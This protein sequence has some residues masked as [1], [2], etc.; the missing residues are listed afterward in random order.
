MG[1]ARV[2]VVVWIAGASR[3]Q[4]TGERASAAGLCCVSPMVYFYSVVLFKEVAVVFLCKREKF[5][6]C[7]I[8]KG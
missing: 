7:H 1:R 4:S 2:T 6:K 3:R 5:T 8:R